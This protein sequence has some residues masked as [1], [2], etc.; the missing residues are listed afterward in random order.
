MKT[1]VLFLFFLTTIAV[2]GQWEHCKG[3]Y[4]GTVNLLKTNG[5]F[6]YMITDSGFYISTD[7]GNNWL[8]KNKDVRNIN[9]KDFIVN[10]NKILYMS[11]NILLKSE[12][13]GNTWTEIIIDSL[14]MI[15]AFS[16]F[17]ESIIAS[18]FGGKQYTYK[19][20]LST[21]NGINWSEKYETK[22]YISSLI[23]SDNG[24]YLI[25]LSRD[26]LF[27]STD[28]GNIWTSKK[29]SIKITTNSSLKWQNGKIFVNLDSGS[30]FITNNL[31]DSWKSV[32]PSLVNTNGSSFVMNENEV[33]I[34]SN[35]G[36]IYK[37]TDEGI[38]W[39][40]SKIENAIIPVTSVLKIN[41][42][43]IAGTKGLGLYISDD[44]GNKWTQTIY[45]TLNC[46]SLSFS[47]KGDT[48]FT[49]MPS[50]WL[51]M[52]TDFGTTWIHK[53]NDNENYGIEDMLI[54]GD[55]IFAVSNR[56]YLSTNMGNTWKQIVSK[57]VGN[58]L[59]HICYNGNTILVGGSTSGI[60]ASKD[61]GKTWERKNNGLTSLKITALAAQD[62]AFFAGTN[63]EGLFVS[64]N[65]GDNWISSYPGFSSKYVKDIIVSNSKVYVI[66]GNT[67]YCSNDFGN[68][69]QKKYEGSFSSLYAY[70]TNIFAG[71]S[72]TIFISKDT[73]N[74]FSEISKGLEY[75]GK[76][77]VNEIYILGNYIFAG[78][79]QGI[80]RAKL[81]DFGIKYFY[82]VPPNT[83]ILSIY[84][85][86]VPGM[87]II[88]FNL[89]EPAHVRIELYDY[90][91]GKIAD[92]LN[93]PK[94]LGKH[95]FSYDTGILSSGLYFVRLAA[96][97][98]SQSCKMIVE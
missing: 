50:V 30:I 22:Q 3:P 86:T 85:G 89:P 1:N 69:W 73:G 95:N 55:S 40:F 94:G 67:I 28:G 71:G 53:G 66:F 32:N 15:S 7:I 45:D 83:C 52:T 39:S 33:F 90:T 9:A 29:N 77:D 80:F 16:T 11:N 35:G 96:G 8:M 56:I 47:S 70:G 60:S 79:N 46:A 5:D 20:M 97:S 19:L 2:S 87:A 31:G 68:S 49:G 92:I 62:S 64:K 26:S 34:G 91:G 6:I 36:G 10:K 57:N 13:N 41:N 21:D 75:T 48:L 74:T 17:G 72:S 24:D 51:F 4:G 43:I 82:E 38:S 27:I 58:T 78:T 23:Y 88:S 93:E 54:L 84:Y 42:R 59:E 44:S 76:N 12:D 61:N 37:S 14:L 65:N 25:G 63:G 98:I 81:S 18:E